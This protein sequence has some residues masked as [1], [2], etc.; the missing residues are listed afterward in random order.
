MNYTNPQIQRLARRIPFLCAAYFVVF[1]F[2]Y[3]WFFQIDLL[4]QVHFHYSQEQAAFHPLFASLLSAFLLLVV[5]IFA[6]L[7]LRWLPLRT[8]AIA[9]LPSFL[10]LGLLTHWRMPQFG[11]TG[12]APGW[13]IYVALVG[14]FLLFLLLARRVTD[15]SKEHSSLS[16]YLWPNFLILILLSVMT[17]CLGN[18]DQRLHRT[19][20][21]A[22]L[23]NE[24][25]YDDVLRVARHEHHPTRQLTAL[26][27]LS[28]SQTGQLGEALFQYPQPYA[29]DGLLPAEADTSLFIS[30]P[31][32]V[33]CHLGFQKTDR[34]PSDLFFSVITHGPRRRPQQR[35]YEL[36]ASLLNRDLEAFAQQ[37]LQGDTLPALLPSHYREALVLRQQLDTLAQPQ[38]IDS[39][40][41]LRYHEFDSLR[42]LSASQSLRQLR[43]LRRFG[44][45]YWAYYF[46]GD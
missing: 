28:L 27:A 15:S 24:G 9:W 16:T 38:L 32:L 43:C 1:A 14:V 20:H 17:V 4:A 18:T 42:H 44:D 23:A 6:S 25:R 11:D 45:T 19:L 5:G 33:G 21:S 40:L 34:T 31:H 3:L 46:F 12:H 13:Y 22:T 36:C 7:H 10:L 37:V 30:L 26:T 39:L 35:D 8:T 2:C 41:T 29:A